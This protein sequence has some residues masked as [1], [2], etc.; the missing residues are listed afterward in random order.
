MSLNSIKNILQFELKE[1]SINNASIYIH[2]LVQ[3]IFMDSSNCNYHEMIDSCD[4]CDRTFHDIRDYSYKM[5]QHL[6]DQLP[7]SSDIRSNI[8]QYLFHD[9]DHFDHTIVYHKKVRK[10]TLN[11]MILRMIVTMK[12][13]SLSLRKI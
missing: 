13:Y 6:L 12:I 5:N 10:E 9:V 11:I 3:L 8:A 7:L 1:Y 4:C 2:I